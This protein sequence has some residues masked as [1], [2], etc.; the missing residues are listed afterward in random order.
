V[1]ARDVIEVLAIILAAGLV[2]DVVAGLVRLPRMVVL[3]GVGILLGPHALD[4]VDVPLDSIGAQLLFSLGVSFIL[5]YGGLE[6]TFD[7]LSRVGVGL[8]LLAVPGVLIT[9]LVVGVAAAWLF[10]IP[11]EAGFLI[12]AVLAPL[13]PAILIPLFERLR[14]R[15]KLVQSIVAESALNDATGAVLAL[16][17]AGFILAGDES[18]SE[19]VVDFVVELGIAIGLGILFGLLL[20]IVLSD[21]RVGVWRESSPIALAALVAAG[22]VSIESAGGSGYMGAFVAGVIAGNAYVL[23]LGPAEAHEAELRGFAARITD[24]VVLLIFVVVGAN[25]P[26]DA[27][28]DDGLPALGVLAVLIVLARPLTVLAS[29]L[30]DRRGRWTRDELLYMAAT[31]E[32]GVVPVALAGIIIAE[33]VPYEDELVT[34]VAV[35]IVV[36]L[37]LLA[38]TKG[39]LARRLDLM[40]P[41]PANGRA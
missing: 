9:A 25:L 3:L 12:G 10:G 15:P 7:V 13:D 23:R 5:F 34:A 38:T 18:L 33:G 2:A 27:I 8:A 21:R 17:I 20:A 31:R 14:V 32:T 41:E 11:F 28:A 36:T 39:W 37:L 16:S 30:P 29:L 4:L 22:Y 1:S 40:E 6:I 19:P 35:A 24:V 26:L